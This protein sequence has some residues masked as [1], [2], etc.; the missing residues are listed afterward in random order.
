MS[1]QRSFHMIIICAIMVGLSVLPKETSLQAQDLTKVGQSGMKFL[2]IPISARADAMGSSF[3]S[4]AEDADALF[5]NAAGLGKL[6]GVQVN[7]HHHQWIADMAQNAI[8]V[9]YN[10][11][12]NYG[13]IGA[14]FVAMDYGDFHG[15]RRSV[16]D[17]GGFTETGT[18]SPTAM[19][20]GVG[21]AAQM[22]DRFYWGGHIRYAYQ[23]LGQSAI[24]HD[25]TDIEEGFFMK[26]N[27][28]GVLVFDFGTIYHTGFRDLRI[29]M[30][31]RNFGNDV[32]YEE[33]PFALPLNF[34]V[35]VAMDIFQL[36]N[37]MGMMDESGMHKMTLSIE[38]ATMR[39]YTERVHFGA[40]YSLQDI[41]FLRAGY[42]VNYD[43]EGLGLG[44]GVKQNFGTF[45][46]KIDYAYKP[47][48][49]FGTLHRFSIGMNF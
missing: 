29:A 32:T 47:Y 15:T 11:G 12:G 30:S 25:P 20:I 28:Q 6:D 2:S 13:T 7:F 8:S 33:E 17:P 36:A 39:D 31:L 19:A 37:S 14:S 34:T 3:I 4:I 40:E 45:G 5:W 41:I 44:A 46:A 10:L 1:L 35:G 23:D 22:T 18:Y 16:T 27:S 9:G 21:Y 26:D 49:V 48:G 24:G 43:E 42:K 38:G